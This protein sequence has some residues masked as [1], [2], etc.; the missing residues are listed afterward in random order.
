MEHDELKL[1]TVSKMFE[2]EKISRELDSC[3]NIDILRNLCK[4]Y[5]KLYFSHQETVASLAGM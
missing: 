5:V 4:C 3:T 1:G 2:F